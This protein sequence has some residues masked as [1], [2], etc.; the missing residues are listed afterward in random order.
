V[1]SIPSRRRILECA[2][3]V[4]LV[5]IVGVAVTVHSEVITAM[6]VGRATAKVARSTPP[7]I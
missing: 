1:R 6:L 5:S 2:S 3:L 4:S 7:V